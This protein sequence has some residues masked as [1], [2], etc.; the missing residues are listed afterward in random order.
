MW[1]M[2]FAVIFGT[3]LMSG[4]ALGGIGV[5]LVWRHI[6][7]S[8]ALS[9]APLF[10][11]LDGDGR[12][13]I[14][15]L[16]E[17]AFGVD[18][19]P[20]AFVTVLAEVDGNLS[21]VDVLPVREGGSQLF[22]L[23][24]SEGGG[25]DLL[26]SSGYWNTSILRL[27]GQ[28]L[29][30]RS[31]SPL[32]GGT[33]LLAVDDIDADG[34]NDLLVGRPQYPNDLLLIDLHSGSTRWQ[35][36]SVY[37]SGRAMVTQLDSDPQLEIV[38]GGSALK[39]LG[40]ADGIEKWTHPIQANGSIL[41]GSFDPDPA[42]RTFA[43]V[44]GNTTIFRSN[45]WSMLSSL[46][47]PWGS[48]SYAVAH[49]VDD[50]GIDDLVFPP[51][52]NQGFGVRDAITG[53]IKT[54][55]DADFS[56]ARIPAFGRLD[57]AGPMLLAYGSTS[58]ITSNGRNGM[59][60]RELA[61][62]VPLYSADLEYGP[63][64]MVTFADVDGDGVQETVR[65]SASRVT[66]PLA[67]IPF[68]VVVT[69][70]DGTE[71]ARRQDVGLRWQHTSPSSAPL[72]MVHVADLDG[73]PGDEIVIAGLSEHH[74]AMVQVLRGSDLSTAWTEY[75][76]MDFESVSVHGL[77]VADFDADGKGD[78][79]V[80]AQK[81]PEIRLIALSG[82][83]GTQLWR[84]INLG[85]LAQGAVGLDALQLDD[86]PAVEIVVS[87]GGAVFA[88]DAA[89]KLLEWTVSESSMSAVSAIAWRESEDCRVGIVDASGSLRVYA[90]SDQQ[91]LHNIA[92]PEST[93]LVI[94]ELDNGWSFLA[95]AD[96][97]L[98]RAAPFRDP[99]ALTG[100]L[101]AELNG[102]RSGGWRRLSQDPPQVELLLGS[103]AQLARIQVSFPDAL[104]RSDFE[105]ITES[106]Q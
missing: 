42:V 77:A 68:N 34:G 17:T 19:S 89:S 9:Q 59:R 73:E 7:Q 63:F 94:P 26:L 54:Q 81:G 3:F 103:V 78:P 6:P 87:L 32:P 52:L 86:D 55:I 28:P 40:G 82:L 45:P 70:L 58:G 31:A 105:Q 72:P 16:A 85:W 91:W 35:A 5:E 8:P 13:E 38:I 51:T 96:G 93:R 14:V 64:S 33:I 46:P 100:Y 53:K 41:M 24:W 22:A 88:F 44:S 37:F 66:Y 48:G 1:M 80:L 83:T 12:N 90:C 23:P 36:D 99:V 56:I 97:Q 74:T 79:V 47:S 50:D 29:A 57:P 18:G 60:V 27:G 104:M 106:L 101:G 65:L 20:D 25:H 43:H 15:Y 71:I 62:D 95:A 67:E 10:V 21:P 84:S 4:A 39:V 30:V 69:S 92:L 49:D 102:H 11:D 98:F 75:L 61:G 76:V 2:R